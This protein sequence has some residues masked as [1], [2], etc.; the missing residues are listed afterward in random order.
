[1]HNVISVMSL[2][3]GGVYVIYLLLRPALKKYFSVRLRIGILKIA[4][5]FSLFPFPLFRS[6]YMDA[7]SGFMN[8]SGFVNKSS[9]FIRVMPNNVIIEPKGFYAVIIISAVCISAACVLLIYKYIIY[10]KFRSGLKLM[11]TDNENDYVNSL[12]ENI[13]KE[14]KVRRSVRILTSRCIDSMTVGLL[15]PVIILPDRQ[16]THIQTEHILKHEYMHIKHGDFVYRIILIF[17]VALHWFNPFMYLLSREFMRLLEYRADEAVVM[18]MSEE[19]KSEYGQTIIDM[20]KQRS[21]LFNAEY[22][23]ISMFGSGS[24]KQMK[25]RLNEMKNVKHRSLKNTIVSVVIAFAV[26]ILNCNFVLAYQEYP[27]YN[28]SESAELY[29]YTEDFDVYMSFD[30]D[31]AI[32]FSE[33]TDYADDMTLDFSNGVDSYFTDENGVSEPVYENSEPQD[34]CNHVYKSGTVTN[35]VK[36]ISGGCTVYTY[37]AQICSKCGNCLKGTLINRVNYKICPH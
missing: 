36:N 35:H 21:D 11:C 29:E 1:M 18:S 28:S 37:N 4:L 6:V 24:E 13:K 25:A 20:A 27:I 17:A 3:A 12:S 23:P 33:D 15:H 26:F 9:N 31:F 5:I 7:V 8:V 34:Y 2:M 22:M 32:P 16:L 30:E 10:S 19:E 14:N